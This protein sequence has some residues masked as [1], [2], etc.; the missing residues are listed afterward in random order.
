MTLRNAGKNFLYGQ[1]HETYEKSFWYMPEIIARIFNR[2]E[3]GGAV[4]K[5]SLRNRGRGI[6]L[7]LSTVTKG[8]GGPK[9]RQKRRYVKFE[10]SLISKCKNDKP[11][12]N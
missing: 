8:E 7:T 12:K 4:S 9:F 1:F 10:W 2:G 3:E 6:L 11:W 5:I